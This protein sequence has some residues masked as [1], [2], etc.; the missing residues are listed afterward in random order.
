MTTAPM[1]DYKIHWLKMMS[2]PESRAVVGRHDGISGR[3]NHF[4]KLGFGKNGFGIDYGRFTVT[5]VLDDLYK[6]RTP[7]LFN[8][9]STPPYGHS[10][11]L[12]ALRDAI[13]AH[14]DPL[15][16]LD[17]DAMTTLSRHEYYKR[18]AAVGDDFTLFGVLTDEE[19]TMVI[20]F[21]ETL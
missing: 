19:V 20:E 5:F 11:S 18:M 9:A 15:R 16:N 14:Y 6:F 4:R 13:V 3:D 10:G 21:L 1:V 7:P 17:T 12:S 8:V 2:V